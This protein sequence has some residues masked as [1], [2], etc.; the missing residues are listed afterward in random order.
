MSVKFSFDSTLKNIINLTIIINVVG[1]FHPLIYIYI[2][3]YIYIV[4][5][6]RKVSLSG[7][8]FM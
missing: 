6:E 1:H 7:L 3:I 2:Y 8:P 5:Q 4:T